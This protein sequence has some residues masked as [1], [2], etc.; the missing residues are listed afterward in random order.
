MMNYINITVRG[1]IARAEAR[2]RVVCGNSDYA[3]RFDFDE[4]W[5][6]YDLKT[7]RFVTEDGSY[8]DVQFEGEDC[9]VPILR[10]A[11]TL[12]VGV[13][14]GNL[15]TTTAALIHAVPCITDP[16]GTPADPTPDVYAQIMER[17]NA[18]EAP[19]AVLYTAQELTDE[20]KATARENIGAEVA[21][22]GAEEVRINVVRADNGR[23]KTFTYYVT[24]GQIIQPAEPVTKDVYTAFLGLSLFGSSATAA[25]F[26]GVTPGEIKRW[27]LLRQNGY[28]SDGLCI[29][30]AD[31]RNYT[32]NFQ[33]RPDLRRVLYAMSS[34]TVSGKATYD[35]EAGA[36]IDS[37]THFRRFVELQDDTAEQFAMKSA[38]TEDMHIA[39]K[40]YV[41]GRVTQSD[42]EQNDETASDYIKNRPFYE[43]VIETL[44]DPTIEN[45][46]KNESVKCSWRVAGVD[47]IDIYPSDL[48]HGA[49]F[50][51]KLGDVTVDVWHGAGILNI[52]PSDADVHILKRESN[53]KQ[54]DPKFI[55]E[56]LFDA[57]GATNAEITAALQENKLC[58]VR[59]ADGFWFCNSYD[60]NSSTESYS[61]TFYRIAEGAYS[62]ID[63]TSKRWTSDGGFDDKRV[64]EAVSTI[65]LKDMAMT[66]VDAYDEITPQS[67][68]TVNGICVGAGSGQGSKTP[69]SG[70]TFPII[71]SLGPTSHGTGSAWVRDADGVVWKGSTDYGTLRVTAVPDVHLNITGAT[72]GQI[73][74]ITAVDDSGKPTAWEAVDM[75][76][77]GG[78]DL[79]WIEVADITTEEQTQQ[80]IIST[81]K[82]GRPISRYNALEMIS[83]IYVPADA[84]QTSNN[85][86][87]WIYPY[88]KI[89][90][91]FYRY[92]ANF[93]TW[94]TITR[95]QSYA[96]AGST[97]GVLWTPASS[98]LALSNVVDMNGDADFMSGLC[99]YVH[100]SGDHIPAGT[101]VRIAVLSKGVTA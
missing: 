67:V 26:S 27:D 66:V 99:V 82:D 55:P 93:A 24:L 45:W 77:G 41:D 80:L 35:I 91:T 89:G 62:S 72:V 46:R 76:S 79:S 50:Q 15:R 60:R 73:A 44:L 28:V 32:K 2:A 31:A 97:T 42:W 56:R 98:S 78:G 20:Q 68:K 85:G 53:I 86:N 96:W 18:I 57:T 39:T 19:A 58:Y 51:Y 87:L 16:D 47:Y 43:G 7:A 54:I 63:Y 100:Q 17:F 74:K 48:E 34:I 94:K 90:T 37:D 5:E 75:P 59:D 61:A 1:K 101:R 14:A 11:R 81:D 64:I 88:P 92:V 30:S 12:L 33:Y 38:P 9:A 8:T 69:P 4:E 22:N 23:E 13:F 36:L 29:I 49:G 65:T 21:H 84:T 40:G 71:F 70:M 25:A 6:A 52:K 10:N 95:T 3:V 83:L